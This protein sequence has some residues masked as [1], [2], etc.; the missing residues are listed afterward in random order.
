LTGANLF[1]DDPQEELMSHPGKM[2]TL[3]L[4]AAQVFQTI[5]G[6][7]VN[8]NAR[9]FDERLMPAMHLLVDDLGATLY[10]VDIWGKSNWID[11][12]GSLGKTT[13]LSPAHLASIHGGEIFQRGWGMLRWLNSRG[14]RP[15]LTASGIVPDW[16]LASDGKTLADLDAFADMMVAML[17]WAKVKEKLDFNL[18]G[19]L[20]ETDIGAPEGPTVDPAGFVR[21]CEILDAKLTARGL[22]DIRLVLAEQSHFGGEYLKALV[23]SS[24][25]RQR[26]AVFGLHDYHDIPQADYAAVSAVVENSAY[27]G[28]PLWM[29]EFGDLEQSGEREWYVA[30]IMFSRLLDHM[31]A[32]FSASLVWDAYD[33]YH[34]HDEHWTIYGLLRTGL[35]AYTPK[36][37]YHAVKHIFR[38]VRPGFQRIALEC[39][40]PGLRAC[41]F[42]S[43]DK[44]QWGIA[45]MNTNQVPA[46]LNARLDGLSLAPQDTHAGYYRTSET[47]NCAL[48]E[49]VPLHGGNWPFTGI[50]VGIPPG[51][52][53]TLTNVR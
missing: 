16:M 48:V 36:K 50:D 15:Y 2:A 52:I 20:N 45:G 39:D 25:L 28:T 21:V 23:A 27:A 17:E 7:G 10:R 29:T 22:D 11:P 14:I 26:T 38:F 42:A 44:S 33:N 13:A 35:R 51:S 3:R 1:D 34:D 32:G 12:D 46:R 18:F 24:A 37:R 41:A 9:Y 49:H 4:N 6:Y 8:I 19:P 53:F 43:A 5:D 31:E 30:W 40:T 47:E